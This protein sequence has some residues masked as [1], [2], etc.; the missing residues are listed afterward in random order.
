MTFIKY[1]VLFVLLSFT[2][3]AAS[4]TLEWTVPEDVN[5]KDI[6]EYVLSYG[7]QTGFSTTLTVRNSKRYTLKNLLEG[8]TYWFQVTPV[9]KNNIKLEPSNMIICRIPEK[10]Q[11]ELNV[12]PK[13]SVKEILME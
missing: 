8:R 10:K 11:K 2:S 1:I 9:D 7:T 5:E 3:F 12:K 4:L 13:L 6:K